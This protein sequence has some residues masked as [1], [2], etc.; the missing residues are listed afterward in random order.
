MAPDRPLDAP[1]PREG[2]WSR[3]LGRL[4]GLGVGTEDPNIVGD[5]G[6]YDVAPG[7]DPD[8][9]ELPVEEADEPLEPERLYAAE[10]AEDAGVAEDLGEGGEPGPLGDRSPA[11]EPPA[12]RDPT[13]LPERPGA[14][15]RPGG[16][17][18]TS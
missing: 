1:A 18:P 12:G 2:W 15:P 17:E 5:A 16:P 14:S 10:V 11:V 9:G 3:L 8:G 4:R 7:R 13:A 6:P